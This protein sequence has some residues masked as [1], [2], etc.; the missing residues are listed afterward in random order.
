[1]K[2]I[3]K[4]LAMFRKDDVDATLAT[5]KKHNLVDELF[6]SWYSGKFDIGSDQVW[7]TWQIE[8]PRMVWYF[9]GQ[10]HIHGYFHLKV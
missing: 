10:P 9:R 6:V 8:G 3:G 4:M 7:D 2:T 5:M 1:M